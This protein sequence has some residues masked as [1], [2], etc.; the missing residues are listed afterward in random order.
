ME[1]S[2][3]AD[4]LCRV[5]LRCFALCCVVLCILRKFGERVFFV[6]DIAGLHRN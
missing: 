6:S 3:T 2:T 5:V 1:K 4:M